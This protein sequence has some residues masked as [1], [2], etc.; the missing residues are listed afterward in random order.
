LVC[1]HRRSR[2][3]LDAPRSQPHELS[4]DEGL[5]WPANADDEQVEM[6]LA[7][8]RGHDESTFIGEYGS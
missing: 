7:C 2:G 6:P 5:R 4:L 1:R 8:Y 3:D